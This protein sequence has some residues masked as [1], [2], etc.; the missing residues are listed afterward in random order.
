MNLITEIH[1]TAKHALND[2]ENDKQFG[3]G[4]IVKVPPEIELIDEDLISRLTAKIYA[5]M[6]EELHKIVCE[7]YKK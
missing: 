3:T 1:L 6:V 4:F 2:E 5:L 7:I